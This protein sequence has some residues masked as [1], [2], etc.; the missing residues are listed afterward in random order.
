MPILRC[1]RSTWARISACRTPRSAGRAAVGALPRNERPVRHAQAGAATQTRSAADDDAR[2]CSRRSSC[3]S[4]PCSSCRRRSSEALETNVMLE[5]RKRTSAIDLSSL[6]QRRTSGESDR[7][8]RRA[9]TES[10]D[11]DE[12]RPRKS[13][14]RW[15]TRGPRPLHRPATARA[16][17]RRPPARVRRRARP[18]PAPAPDLAAGDQPPRP[19]PGLDRRGDRRRAERRRLPDASRSTRSRRA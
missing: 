3:C 8:T 6:D 14:S 18:R 15:K 16:G 1:V 17:R 7:G 12:P 5:A 19:A 9:K 10:T 11:P 2:S 4:C 13:S